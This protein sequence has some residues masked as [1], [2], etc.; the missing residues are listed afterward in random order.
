MPANC[1]AKAASARA[2]AT[3]MA[4]EF[5]CPSPV[6][7][8]PSSMPWGTDP[9]DLKWLATTTKFFPVRGAET[10]GANS[11][12]R[13]WRA[14]PVN[15]GSSRIF[16]SPTGSMVARRYMKATRMTSSSAGTAAGLGTW[17]HTC[18][19]ACAL[20][21]STRAFSAPSRS[22][23]APA[24]TGFSISSSA[25]TSAPIALMACTIFV[26]WFSKAA[27]DHAPRTLH[28]F[29]VTKAPSRSG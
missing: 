11:W 9:L 16:D 21:A 20:S 1:S 8:L 10:T 22:C 5:P 13:G 26:C 27:R 28:F 19:P 4:L 3:R 23:P 25:T 15:A 24:A 6:S 7:L 17:A 2:W 29:A 18:S 14:R 12:A